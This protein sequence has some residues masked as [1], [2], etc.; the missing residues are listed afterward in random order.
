MIS[1]IVSN[2]LQI[3]GLPNSYYPYLQSLCKFNVEA[4]QT[5]DIPAILDLF[6]II[7]SNTIS[8]PKGFLNLVTE[9]L[10]KNNLQ[11][12]VQYQT[13]KA[14]PLNLTINPNIK[15]QEGIFGYQG[16]V[17]NELLN[18]NACRLEASAGCGKTV[19]AC[20]ATG[21]LNKGPMLFLVNRDRLLRQFINTAKK[22]LGLQ[23]DDIG[24]IKA[25]KKTLK[26]IT[27]GSL[28][29][30][31]KESFDLEELK[32]YFNLVFFDECHISS[33]LT[34]RRVILGLAPERLYGLSATPEHYS[35]QD[36]NNL[37]LGLLGP[38]AVKINDWEIPDRISPLTATRDTGMT[39]YYNVSS[40]DPEWKIYKCRNKL[41]TEIATNEERNNLIIKD[42]K[43]L[44]KRGHK[45]LILTSRVIHA[46]ILATKL[47]E[48]G[49][50]F[51]FPYKVIKR[52][53]KDDD[54]KVD[55]KKLDEDVDLVQ[56][57]KLDGLIGTYT[58]FQTGF[59]CQALSAALFAS[60]FSGENSTMIV[61]AVGRIQRHFFNKTEAIVI[62]YT[63][64]SHPVNTLRKWSN[65][66]AEYLIKKYGRHEYL[67]PKK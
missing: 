41:F 8:I 4:Y 17:V 52:K 46:E 30:L 35:S 36:L 37:M 2:K 38:I 6:E 11:Y 25:K 61:Q 44:V 27:V 65:D 43:K 1:C 50:N 10:K 32:N 62:D 58:L 9:L 40:R 7:D 5:T 23:E 20:I 56:E 31:G 3:S 54:Q 24:V 42:A 48:A 26:P 34:Y 12:T 64:D 13:A 51:S 60:P 45:V 29:T 67:T 18:H 19:I 39:F 28:Q 66:R 14:I 33:A 59:D 53:G 16:R 15:Y 21:L 47:K 22:V 49:L 57:D 63:D 55:H